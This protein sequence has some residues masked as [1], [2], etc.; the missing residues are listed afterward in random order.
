VSGILKRR[1][2][3]CELDPNPVRILDESEESPAF[4][5]RGPTTRRTPVKQLS[6]RSFHVLA[7][8]RDVIQLVAVPEGAVEELGT[9]R[10]P[11]QLQ[12]GS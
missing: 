11:V 12:T 10:I 7:F 9:L 3:T 5:E 4:D 1:V 2:W 6:I 8:E